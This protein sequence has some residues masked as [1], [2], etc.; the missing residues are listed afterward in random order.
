MA[1]RIQTDQTLY[2]YEAEGDTIFPAT[3]SWSILWMYRHESDLDIA[4]LLAV[5]YGDVAATIH[6]GVHV[7]AD[8]STVTLRGANG[9]AT[10]T[11]TG[12]ISLEVGR[13]YRFSLIHNSGAGTVTFCNDGVPLLSMAFSPAAGTAGSRSLHFAGYGGASAGSP[14]GNVDSTWA[15]MRIWT[16]VLTEAEQKAE[17]RSLTPVRTSGLVNDWPMPAGSGR[18]NPASGTT[19]AIKIYPTTPLVDGTDLGNG[20][21]ELIYRSSNQGADSSLANTSISA[22]APSGVTQGDLEVMWGYCGVLSPGVPPTMAAPAGWTRAGFQA[23]HY[24]AA[25]GAVNV[26]GHLFYRIAPA[27]NGAAVLNAGTNAIFVYSRSAYSNGNSAT[28]FGQVVFGSGG[29][30]TSAVLSSLTTARARSLLSAFITQGSAQSITPPADMIE[31]QDNAA[32][33]VSLHDKNQLAAGASGTKT[34]TL[35][36]SGDFGWGFAEFYSQQ[37]TV[38][39][40]LSKTLDGLTVSAAGTVRVSAALAKTLAALTAAGAGTVRVSGQFAQALAPMTASSAGQVRVAGALSQTLG[41][42]TLAATG[43]VGS[44]PIVGTAAIQL[45]SLTA[46]AAGQVRVSGVAAVALAPATLASA[47]AVRASGAL[48]ATLGAIGLSASGSMR[49]AG[50]MATTLAPATLS[51]TG[52]VGTAPVTGGLA[53]TLAPLTAVASAVARVSGSLAR[54][55]GDVTL[56]AGGGARVTGQLAVVLDAMQVS[57]SGGGV[58]VGSASIV[59]EGVSLIATGTVLTLSQQP[60]LYVARVPA[61]QMR[62]VVSAENTTAFVPAEEVSAAVPEGDYIAT[63]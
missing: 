2:L 45:Q 16:A 37:A 12:S 52:V 20:P 1:V 36:A 24:S 40:S 61:S 13:E 21:G 17:F 8:G 54:T 34:F 7:A 51:A 48:A 25:G 30:S 31:R 15:R 23:S 26:R 46:A 33:G 53:V 49:V 42:V 28:P 57:A 59:L 6:C 41:D 9:G 11:A 4:S 10:T 58:T 14:P 47:G 55:L 27:S 5:L 35:P 29:P 62:A 63:V 3:G 22:P 56:S 43:V 39:G 50:A 44:T 38:S 19:Q 32:A 18:F 60:S